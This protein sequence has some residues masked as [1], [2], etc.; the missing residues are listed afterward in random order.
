MTLYV[1]NHMDNLIASLE[2]VNIQKSDECAA[3]I[4]HDA[5]VILHCHLESIASD[6]YCCVPIHMCKMQR[7]LYIN[8][9]LLYADLVAEFKRMGHGAEILELM[10]YVDDY[11]CH[12]A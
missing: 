1:M 2:N 8:S 12:F 9:K 11:L 5:H 6:A 4:T 10:P 7:G 3:I